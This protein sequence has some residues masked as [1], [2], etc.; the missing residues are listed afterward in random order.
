MQVEGQESLG[1]L[2]SVQR[3]LGCPECRKGAEYFFVP[4]FLFVT[5]SPES[6]FC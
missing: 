1:T 5:Q 4:S 3:E 2:K 6:C